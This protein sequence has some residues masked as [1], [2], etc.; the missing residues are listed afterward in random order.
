MSIILNMGMF[1]WIGRLTGRSPVTTFA[2][3]QTFGV[4]STR[5]YSMA[6]ALASGLLTEGTSTRA[7]AL[8]VPAVLNGRNM[9]CNV[10]TIPLVLLDTSRKV[11][12][13][14]PALL[15]QIDP[16]VANVVTLAATIE[17]L[18][19]DGIGWW[20]KLSYG[21]NGFP[22]HARHVDSARVTINPPADYVNRLPSGFDPRSTIYVDGKPR[23]AFDFIRFDSPK[24]ALLIAARRAI[25]RAALLEDTAEMYAGDPR[26]M[27]YFTPKENAG[28][29]D[30]DKVRKIIREWIMARRKRATGFVPETL[31]Y[32]TVQSPNPQELQLAQLQKQATLDIANAIGVDPEDLGVSTTSRTYQNDI[33]REQH[34]VNDV[35]AAF[36]LAITQRL[37]MNDVTRRGYRVAFLLDD[38]LKA[39]PG[40]RWEI[41][42]RALAMGVTNVEEIRARED[43][44]E[45]FTPPKP[46]PVPALPP[47]A[48][49]VSRET[50]AS[51]GADVSRETSAVEASAVG[52]VV[53]L[54]DEGELVQLRF[55]TEQTTFTA[56]RASRTITGTILVYDEV[57]DNGRGRFRFRRGSLRWNKAAVSRVK[58]L[59]DHDWKQLLGSA[60][61][62][63]DHGATVTASYKVVRGPA[64]D[65][66]LSEAEDGALDGLSVGIDVLAGTPAADGVVDVSEAFMNETSLTPRPAFDSAR[67]TSVTAHNTGG[68]MDCTK[69]GKN[70]A[71]NAACTPDTG[72]TVDVAALAAALAGNAEFAKL[73]AGHAPE[74]VEP[75]EPGPDRV[76][77]ASRPT[78]VELD[79]AGDNGTS[80]TSAVPTSPYRFDRAGR[81]VAGENDFSTDLVNMLKAGD[82]RG[83][84][85]EFGKRV[86]AHVAANAETFEVASGD[87]ATLNPVIDQPDRYYEAP[88]QPVPLWQMVNKGAPPNGIEPF[89][90]PK[91]GTE[92]NLVNDHVEGVEPDSGEVTTTSQTITPSP[93]SGKVSVTREVWDMGG[94]PA[95][96]NI[97]WRRMRRAYRRELET[98][99]STFLAGMA[100]A[101]GNTVALT[102][103]DDAELAR[104]LKALIVS[105]NFR[106]DYSWDAFAME[107]NLY[108]DTS[109]AEAPDG[110]PYFPAIN[111]SNADGTAAALWQR[112]NIN[113]LIGTPAAGLAS[114][115][116]ANPS[117][118]F[119]REV[120]HGYATEPRRFEFAGTSAPTTEDPKGSYAPVAMVDI[121]IWGYKA[122]ALIDPEGVLKVN[123]TPIPVVP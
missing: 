30:A 69:C 18:L 59:R 52:E 33:T 102:P 72:P 20:E 89:R 93:L 5:Y 121:A 82:E 12:R 92:S 45:A 70:H 119:D 87:V 21:W 24:P 68:M 11:V 96:S 94:N 111:P 35:L 66:A 60:I 56:D 65:Q 107:R 103:A 54:H 105:L 75:P 27:D 101:A 117:F 115:A 3:E 73:F 1:S 99:T 79:K 26:A 22:A 64:G 118:L 91:F 9:I 7:Q 83:D 76:N 39:D 13:G 47:A 49:D 100:I 113:G 55:D 10:A 16:D 109:E 51:A 25:H 43:W 32:N 81:F 2:V 6:D 80:G 74:P 61:D 23:S 19:M 37:S 90:L 40:T 42:E 122:H 31:E 28:S 98:S 85:T 48:G 62:V 116:A 36:M 15:E 104:E 57:V 88:D 86:M 63:R 110:R 14:D 78:P 120:V 17:D 71:A 95:V 29:L 123:Y 46:K 106:P 97:I 108:T 112:L 34:K 4:E 114:G 58:L 41:H 77:S 50:S 8:A 84:R 44:P 67:L 38:Y 53:H